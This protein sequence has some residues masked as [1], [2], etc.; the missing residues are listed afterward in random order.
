MT[1]DS[2]PVFYRVQ[3]F[4]SD[5]H[6]RWAAF[7][8]RIGLPWRYKPRPIEVD[9]TACVPD[10]LIT[11]DDTTIVH[12]AAPIDPDIRPLRVYL[13]GKMSTAHEWRGEAASTSRNHRDGVG[14]WE[15]AE[16]PA[17]A[18]LDNAR[19]ASLDGAPFELIGPFPSSCDH[20]CSHNP[21]SCHM[22]ET[23][24]DSRPTAILTA[25]FETLA[26]ADLLCAHI[27]T[28]EAYGTIAEI[29]WA[30]ARK[31]PTSLTLDWDLCAELIRHR[32][33]KLHWQGAV[34][35]HDLWFIETMVQQARGSV[36]AQVHD[37]GE[38]RKHHAAVIANRTHPTYGAIARVG[39]AHAAALTFGDP[40]DVATGSPGH[41][42]GKGDR[43]REL[44]REN[45]AAA[46]AVS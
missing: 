19:T 26:K 42:F 27:G 6:A 24:S 5:C 22:A 21:T 1:T 16:N 35:S 25:C 41:W 36:S 17:T 2:T 7:Y 40:L 37:A 46:A 28:P 12:T 8:D 33:G 43:L 9:G 11:V 14:D 23:C 30:V 44:C 4:Q 34:G 32:G 31:I 45:R 20:G 3:K 18:W 38:A 39:Q 10:F 15:L 29:A 13:G